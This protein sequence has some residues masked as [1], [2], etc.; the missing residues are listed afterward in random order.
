MRNG[1]RFRN[2]TVGVTYEYSGMW[3]PVLVEDPNGCRYC[4]APQRDHCRRWVSWA[5]NH[6]WTEPT[7]QQRLHRMQWRRHLAAPRYLRNSLARRVI[8]YPDVVPFTLAQPK[9]TR[10]TR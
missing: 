1:T 10:R 3:H 6:G 9:K 8:T 5:G 4:D 7:D 2:E